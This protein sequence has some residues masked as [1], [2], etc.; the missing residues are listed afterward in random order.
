VD[1]HGDSLWVKNHSN[2]YLYNNGSFYLNG[3]IVKSKGFLK[4]VGRALES[5][6]N[7]EE[8][9]SLIQELSSSNNSFTIVRGD[10]DQFSA[11]DII[12]AYGIERIVTFDS[13]VEYNGLE[14]VVGGS[15][16]VITWNP[17]GVSLPTTQGLTKTPFAD[18]A[19]EMFHALDANRGLLT[20]EKTLGI[21]NNE[22]Q[23]VYRDNTLRSQAGLPLRTHYQVAINAYGVRI[24]GA[25][26]RMLTMDNQIIKP[27]W[28]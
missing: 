27:S 9:A 26:P 22:W 23:A 1:Y 3:Q 11:S 6:I 2:E 13:Y 10:D 16:G 28:Y 14:S 17:N 20:S 21:K 18:L 5:I 15:G 25:G 12:K 7:T 4:S 24:G 8:G 19:H